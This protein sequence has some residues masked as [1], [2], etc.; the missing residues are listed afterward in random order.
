MY[1]WFCVRVWFTYHTP[2]LVHS[3]TVYIGDEE[4]FEA[5]D[6]S[7]SSL[8]QCAAVNELGAYVCNSNNGN[9]VNE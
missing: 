4:F 3:G 9:Q 8:P 1:V 5:L 6:Y 7:Q 2:R